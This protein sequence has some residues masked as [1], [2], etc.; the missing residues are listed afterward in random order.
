M[1][2]RVAG[3]EIHGLIGR[4]GMASVY[5]ARQV[6]LDR[7]VA[8]KELDPPLA[9]DPQLVSWFLAESRV[10]GGLAHPNV[11]TVYDYFEYRGLPYIAMEHLARGSLRPYMTG[12]TPAQIAGILDGVLG[13]L[14]HAHAHGVVHCDVKPENVLVT[15]DGRVKLADFGIAR[16]I[17]RVMRGRR[18]AGTLAYMAPEYAAS[19]AVAPSVDLW[20][21]GV[22]AWELI[23]G[24]L[25]PGPK[26]EVAAPGVDRRLAAWVD[27]LLETD[28]AKRIDGA[29]AACEQLE[30]LMLRLHGPRWRRGASLDTQVPAP[31]PSGRRR[32]RMKAGLSFAAAG[33]AGVVLAA[34][35]PPPEPVSVAAMRDAVPLPFPSA[36]P[37]P[38]LRWTGPHEVRAVSSGGPVRVSFR[39]AARRGGTALRV[40]CAPAT[41]SAFAVG[42][43]PVRCAAAGRH[44]SFRVVVTAAPPIAAAARAPR[45]AKKRPKGIAIY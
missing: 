32:T 41:G 5:L 7:L 36:A 29:P 45:T 2:A 27:R 20:S 23:A 30:E 19:A 38:P 31:V 10:A 9:S 44:R 34:G 42:S 1:P 39:V 21:V 14:A 6:K 12:R 4:G 40:R 15:A 26:L 3:Y 35:T 18:P 22:I 17:D 33:A 24:S 16:A 13:G 37:T 25:P 8:L 11:V 43:T 28:P